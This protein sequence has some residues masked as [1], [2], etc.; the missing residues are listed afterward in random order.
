MP[1]LP[2]VPIL[3]YLAL[4]ILLVCYVLCNCPTHPLNLLV[5]A[6]GFPS[7]LH[8]PSCAF[9]SGLTLALCASFCWCLY[10]CVFPLPISSPIFV[11]CHFPTSP[12]NSPS[13]TVCALYPPLPVPCYRLVSVS[14]L[15]IA[16]FQAVAVAGW[17]T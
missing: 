16:V 9:V 3:W 6:F 10:I 17:L 1:I 4:P 8:L 14:L 2:L 11:L 12:H 13:F 7:T 15:F 5:C